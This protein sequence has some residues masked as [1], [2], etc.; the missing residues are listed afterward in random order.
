[1]AE[2]DS[3]LYRYLN[4]RQESVAESALR[5]IV[6]TGVLVIDAE[7]GSL[8]AYDD[9]SKDLCFTL[10][11]GSEA[12]QQNL[13]GQ[14][15]PLNM[16]ITGLAA[17]T[18]EVHIGAPTYKDVR[19]LERTDSSAKDP[20]AVIAAPMVLNDNLIGVI[21]A[22]SFKPGKRFTSHDASVYG[23]FA[24]IAALVIDQEQRLTR[25]ERAT[26][27]TFTPSA[28]SDEA[29]AKIAASLG[30]IA[31]ERPHLLRHVASMIERTE[32]IAF[33]EDFE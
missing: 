32:K 17:A 7:E 27:S 8:L 30:R 2:F 15:V 5:L 3:L 22:I 28:I 33:G 9:E 19:Q 24:A 10:N 18:R 14:R 21:T 25:Y 11:T 26:E 23:S 20:E 29:E 4:I 12:A 6:R 1:M 13:I 31:R 16:G